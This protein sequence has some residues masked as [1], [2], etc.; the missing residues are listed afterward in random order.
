MRFRDGD[1]GIR[2]P[3]QTC[4]PMAST[5]VAFGL[6]F[7]WLYAR[8]QAFIHP[9][10]LCFPRSTQAFLRSSSCF[11]R[12]PAL[13]SCSD[14][15]CLLSCF[16]QREQVLLRQRRTRLLSWQINLL[17]VSRVGALHAVIDLIYRLSKPK[18]PLR[19]SC[20]SYYTL[21]SEQKQVWFNIPSF[22]V[23][24]VCRAMHPER[25]ILAGDRKNEDRP[26][27]PEA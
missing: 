11:Y 16:T 2:T 15:T 9:I 13:M 10:L 20:V 14:R 21:K 17:L 12:Y 24:A 3:V 7:G 25:R 4:H 22:S 5:C 18:H 6:V 8:W 19:L 26:H 1:A 27:R 23:P